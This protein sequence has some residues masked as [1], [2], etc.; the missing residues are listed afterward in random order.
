MN[1][2]D[3]AWL[4]AVAG[5]SSALCLSAGRTL[6]ATFDEPFY[7]EKGLEHWR[8]GSYRTL[9]RAGTMPL[10]VDAQTLPL[11]LWERHRGAPVDFGD[12]LPVVRAM[13]LPFWWL[14]LLSAF[15]LAR[16]FGGPWA[17]RFAVAFI[18]C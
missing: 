12:A 14:L 13:N 17:G 9:M 1:R 4:L 10:P 3:I 6:G 11:H 15:R 2:T 5:L 18:A 7:L 16:R 8:T